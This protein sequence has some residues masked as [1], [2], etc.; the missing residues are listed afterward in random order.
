MSAGNEVIFIATIHRMS[1]RII[2]AINDLQKEFEVKIINFGQASFNTKYDSSLNYQNYVVDNFKESGIFNTSGVFSSSRH[3]HDKQSKELIS[4]LGDIISNNTVAIILDDSR[5]SLYSD[6][7]YKIA[8]N[9]NIT[10]FAN[11]HGNGSYYIPPKRIYDYLF[12]LGEYDKAR[13]VSLGMDSAR[14]LCGGIPA[15]DSL[16]DCVRTNEYILVLTNF[17]FDGCSHVPFSFDVLHKMKIIELQQKLGSRVLF[18]LKHRMQCDRQK[19]LDIIHKSFSGFDLIYDVVHNVESE[20]SL[21]SGASCVLTYGSTMALKPIQLN[22]PTV[23]FKECGSLGC[24]EDYLG[25]IGLE[26]SYEYVFEEGFMKTQRINFLSRV[27]AGSD[28]FMSTSLYLNKFQL[29]IGAI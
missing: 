15:N 3:S 12:C 16:K 6:D 8:K 7:L 5:D 20:N 29:N 17:I 18:K 21:V 22:I 19:E 10:V 11:A 26:E 2:C 28:Y 23:I 4:I 24:F 25:T 1:E 13:Y 14:L 9:K 27:L